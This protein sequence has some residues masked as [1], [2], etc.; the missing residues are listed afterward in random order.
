MLVFK[1]IT[2]IVL[3]SICCIVISKES[4]ST[5]SCIDGPW[6]KPRPSPEGK[7]YVE[8]LAWKHNTCCYANLTRE[9]LENEVLGLYNWTYDVCGNISDQCRRYIL[10][11]EC[12]YQCEPNVVKWIAPSNDT[13]VNVPICASYC[14]AW[15]D[16]CKNDLT[17]A[18]NWLTDYDRYPDHGLNKCAVNRPC[19][20]FAEMFHNGTGL[21]NQMWGDAFRYETSSNCMVMDFDQNGPNPNNKVQP[22]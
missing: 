18:L 20:T 17:C 11:E 10:Q 1:D 21:C 5:E 4:G 2:V 8:C 13:F 19:I 12:F 6:H 15:F 22:S 7:D 16:A 3:A 14:D 9:L